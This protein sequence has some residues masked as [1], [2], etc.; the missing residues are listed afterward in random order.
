MG[1]KEFTT[2]EKIRMV[3]LN[4]QEGKDCG[5]ISRRYGVPQSTLRYW[6]RKYKTFGIDG[7]T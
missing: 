2:E 7:L 5:W 1:K 3:E 6:I 4:L